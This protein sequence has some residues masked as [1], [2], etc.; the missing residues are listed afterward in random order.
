M[1]EFSAVLKKSSEFSLFLSLWD[2]GR[3]GTLAPAPGSSAGFIVARAA[4]FSPR[5]YLA[6]A[7]SEREAERLSRELE[8]YTGLAPLLFPASA[9]GGDPLVEGERRGILARLVAVGKG[10]PPLV[11]SPASL[12]DDLPPPSAFLSALIR[13]APGD[14]SDPVRLARKLVELGYEYED[15]VLERGNFARR[16]GILDLFPVEGEYPLRVEFDGEVIESIRRFDPL[17]QRS[18]GAADPVDL[19]PLKGSGTASLLDYLPAG[20]RIVSAGSFASD[21]AGWG[22]GKFPRLFFF[23]DTLELPAGKG[24][25]ALRFS[26]H[27]LERFKYRSD[28][29]PYPLLAAVGELLEDGYRILLFA[30]NPGESER[31]EEILTEKKISPHHNLKVAIGETVEGFVWEEPRLAVLGDSEIFSRYRLPRPRQ[32]YH[33]AAP[34]LPRADFQ[35]GDWVVHLDHGIGRF[36]GVREITVAGGCQREM[37]V[38]RYAEN[39]RLYCDLTQAHLV[40]RYLGAGKARP[41]L[42]R[43]GGGRWPRARRDARRAVGDLAAELLELQAR[44]RAAGGRR[45]SPDTPWQ[46]EFEAAFIYPETPDQSRALAEIKK[47]LET[48]R[49][50]DRLLCGDVGYGKTEVAVRAAF[51]TAMEGAQT[52]VLVPTTILAQQHTRTF[53]E[54]MSDYPLRVESLSRL[55]SPKRQKEIVADLKEGKVDIVIGTHRLLQ[56]DIAFRDLGLVIIDEEQRFGVRHKEKLK[57]IREQVDLLTLTATPIPRTLYLSLAGARDLSSITTPP[58]D[59]LA[60]ETRVVPYNP[61]VIRNAVERE[62]RRGGQVFYLHN[63]VKDIDQVRAK[64]VTWFPG[65]N[66]ASGHGRMD[67]EELAEVMERFAGGEI[68]LLVCT[69]I[70]ESGLDIPNAN[71]IIVENA[72]RFGLADLYQLRGRVGRFKHLAYAYFFY[73]PGAFLEDAARQRLLAIEEFS[74]LGAGYGLALRDLEIRGAGNILG[75]EQHGHIAA[76]G[77]ELYCRLLEESVARLKGEEKA[78]A[79]KTAIEFEIPAAL[80]LGYVGTETQRIEIYRRWAS[81]G[82]AQEIEEWL[83]ELK[84]RFGPPPKEARLLSELVLF[85]LTA[86]EKGITAIRRVEEKYVLLKGDKILKAWPGPP[87]D[88][89]AAL[90]QFLTEASRKTKTL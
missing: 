10:I 79:P 43:L 15:P 1:E 49:P 50:M 61:R 35:P 18:F 80:S 12:G 85:K 33:G 52:A 57:R 4:A 47:D 41:K 90:S 23:P 45:F 34:G 26:L 73:P 20:C 84:D 16:G 72:H 83:E 13:I 75:R 82:S 55:V 7:P 32:K 70:I 53:R 51:K 24:F 42:D 37:L 14:T 29:A 38:I 68:D 65:L 17:T 19:H 56:G 89:P 58:Q 28:N 21:E 78:P 48:P 6:V 59:R 22:R 30:H 2:S 86:A 87:P 36:L 88:T 8:G 11:A 69:T 25:S 27:N 54:R 5:P 44:R 66:I 76:V 9:G 67:E 46:K 74:Q 71:T 64:L 31:L 60:V 63:R 3:D 81:L 62:V 77:F 40:S 39:A